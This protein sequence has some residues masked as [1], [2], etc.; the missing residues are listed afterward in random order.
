MKT[1]PS[2]ALRST[3]LVAGLAVIATSALA[4]EIPAPTTASEPSRFALVAEAGTAGIGPSLVYTVNPKFT[5]TVGYTWLD[6]NYD[7]ESDDNEYDGK[8][9]LSNFK[10]IA[11]WHPWGGTFHFSGGVFASDNKVDVTLRPTERQTYE[12]NGREYSSTLINSLGGS[13]TF[14]DD[15]APYIGIGWAKNP[16]NSGLSFYATLGV[17]FAGD[18]SANLSATGPITLD[19]QFQADLRAEERDINDDLEDLGAYPVLQLGILYRF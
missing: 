11:N 9:K 16:A 15:I 7:V 18:A 5:V 3:C 10:A 13:A 6:H 8:L 14:E 1:L 19:P 4:Q 12:I 2:P 17:F